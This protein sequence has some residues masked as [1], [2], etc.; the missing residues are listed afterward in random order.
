MGQI[1][2]V[3][4]YWVI[5]DNTNGV[6]ITFD[7]EEEAK[8]YIK[9]HTTPINSFHIEFNSN[10]EYVEDLYRRYSGCLQYIVSFIND[11]IVSDQGSE[12]DYTNTSLLEYISEDA[13]LVSIIAKSEEDAIQKAISIRTKYLNKEPLEGVY[14]FHL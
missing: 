12:F 9:E 5:N 13:N 6:E 4:K 14:I 11:V 2:I 7:T 10:R 3:E 1:K 8:Q